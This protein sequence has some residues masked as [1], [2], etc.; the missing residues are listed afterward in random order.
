MHRIFCLLAAGAVGFGPAASEAQD[1]VVFAEVGGY[2]GTPSETAPTQLRTTVISPLVGGFAR[3][4]ERLQLGLLWGAAYAS[5]EAAGAGSLEGN[6][7]E[8]GNPYALA[9]YAFPLGDRLMLRVGGGLTVPLAFRRSD[10]D[11]GDSV[12]SLGL[13]VAA[14]MRGNWNA[15]LFAE[16]T[17]AIVLPSARLDYAFRFPL[18]IGVEL[19]TAVL[20]DTSGDRD[21]AEFATQLKLE[22]FYTFSRWLRLGLRVRGVWV[23]TVPGDNA[24]VAI[25]PFVRAL[26]GPT[27]TEVRLVMNLDRPSGFAFDEGGIW[28]LH[29]GVGASF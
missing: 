3:I 16:D 14:A 13:R 24:Q 21:A 11:F 19:A 25:E 23:P 18:R 5:A 28:G 26:L 29:V 2:G 17:M 15:W 27:F 8:I 9:A 10:P 12:G 4:G 6:Q 22:G 7:F 20:I 1:V